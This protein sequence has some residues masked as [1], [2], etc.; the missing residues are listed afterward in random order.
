MLDPSASSTTVVSNSAVTYTWN[1]DAGTLSPLQPAAPNQIV[2]W[3]T[4]GT[5]SLSLTVT[6]IGG[7]HTVT[8]TITVGS[9][10]ATGL[11]NDTGLDWCSE[12]VTTGA[13]VNNAVCSDAVNWSANLWVTAQD[14]Y[15]GRDAQARAGTLTKTGAGMAGFDFTKLGASGK[16]LAAQTN[17]WS[18]DTGTEAAS[19]QWDCVR[20]NTTGLIWEVKRNDV[21]HLRHMGNTY[22]WYNTAATTNGGSAGSPNATN[23]VCTASAT[24]PCNTTSY[25]AAVNAL[26]A[27]QAL[28][29]FRDW[30]LPSQ[31]ELSTLTHLGRSNPAID[32]DFFPNTA[33]LPFWTASPDAK[34]PSNALYINF[35]YGQTDAS[36]AVTKAT[37]YRVRLV[38]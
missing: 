21:N 7:S 25:S 15:F 32:S 36:A 38:R 6:D 2:S 30:R 24:T 19:T 5:K 35:L 10:V 18:E 3:T 9:L 14:G 16:P 12:N 23:P 28:C 31:D 4:A 8:Q 27:A 1:Y 34:T 26:P 29:G 22:T 20:D 33:A 37:P 17:A 11:F 13:W